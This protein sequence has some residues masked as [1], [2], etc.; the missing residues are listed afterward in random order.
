MILT[1]LFFTLGTDPCRADSTTA[2]KLYVPSFRFHDKPLWRSKHVE[3][4]AAARGYAA[5][6]ASDSHGFGKYSCAKRRQTNPGLVNGPNGQRRRAYVF[7][8]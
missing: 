3:R 4:M 2:G 1:A 7:Q 6:F 5:Q 8:G